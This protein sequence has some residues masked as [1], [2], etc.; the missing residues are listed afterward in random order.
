MD[1][2][3]LIV[4]IV[5]IA[6]YIIVGALT[7]LSFF[8]VYILLR[9]GRNVAVTVIISALYAIFFLTILGASYRILQTF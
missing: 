6:Y 4:K 5:T 7:L 9:Y 8:S 2:T 1:N 3:E